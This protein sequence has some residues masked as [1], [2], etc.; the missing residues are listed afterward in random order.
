MKLFVVIVLGVLASF[1]L[2][3]LAEQIVFSSMPK[4]ARLLFPELLVVAVTVG[5]LVG[6]MGRHKARIAAALSLAPW[7]VWLILATNG[8]QS[9]VSRWVT[10]I[11]V[12]SVYFALGIGAAALVGGRM[13]RS[14]A[15]GGG[16]SPSQG[17]A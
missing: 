11:A 13:A 14:A 9:T 2:T 3:I 7:A 4:S 8:S 16:R 15:R 5:A 17:H 12:V 1:A 6:L 10:T